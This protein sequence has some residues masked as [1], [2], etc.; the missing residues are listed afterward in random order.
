MSHLTSVS[1]N[2][3][4]YKM[5]I[6]EYTIPNDH[7]SYK[8]DNLIIIFHLLIKHSLSI[9]YVL[10]TRLNIDYQKPVLPLTKDYITDATVNVS[11]IF[12]H[13]IYT[14]SWESRYYDL[15]QQK[16]KRER[17]RDLEGLLLLLL[18]SHFSPASTVSAKIQAQESVTPIPMFNQNIMLPPR[19]LWSNISQNVILKSPAPEFLGVLI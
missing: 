4:I 6:L 11:H 15:L 14:I 5:R 18:L 8:Y 19:S 13:L 12:S 10:G 16:K 17:K 3:L 2:F 9:S 7:S 1:L